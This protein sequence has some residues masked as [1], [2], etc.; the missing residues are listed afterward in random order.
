MPSTYSNLK[1]QLMATG[2]NASTWG[3]VTNT[4]LGTAIE[5]AIVGSA[6]VVF[7][8]G[9]VT[10]TLSDTNGTQPARNMRLNLTGTTGGS[11]RNLVV[12]SIEKPYIINN[13]CADNVVVKTAAGTGVTVPP[14]KTMWVYSDGANVVNVTTHLTD[15]TLGSPLP[16]ASGGLGNNTGSGAALTS[17][18]ASNISSGTL[19]LARGG[20]GASTNS[21]ARVNLLPSYTGNAGKILA[22]N[23][24]GTDVEWVSAGGSGTVNSVNASTSISGLSFSGG[25]ITSSGT[26]TLSGTLGAQGGGTGLTSPGT[27]G[28]VLTSNGTAWV[29]Q[30]FTFSGTLAV[31]NGGTGQNTY[32]DGQL[33]I[34]NS[35]TGGLAKAN[36][37]AGSGISITNGAGTITIA[38]TASGGTVTSVSGTGSANGLSLSGTVTTTGN[39]TLSGSVTSVATTA[40]IDGVTIGY[41]SIPRSTTSGTATTGDVGKCIAVSAGLTIPASTFAAGD[42]VSVY[43]NSASAVTLTQGSGLT[44]RLAGTTTTGNRTLAARGIATIWFN[45]A[46]EAVIS[47]A[48]VT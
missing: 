44:L 18:N 32:T 13:G 26:L 30:A 9:N 20:T 39:I 41:R 38:S 4:N 42:A 31:A 15:L 16:I 29:S 23:V 33:L 22:L 34:G 47:G 7:A 35:S 2:E 28:N 48:G 10:L 1:I 19:A 21:A 37:T 8:S 40:T 14:G 25:P 6:D 24:G 11:T 36:L 27:A 46:T 17:L 3:T 45:S 5:E 12:P 43:N